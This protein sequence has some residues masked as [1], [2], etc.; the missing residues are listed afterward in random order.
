M[1]R[2]TFDEHADPRLPAAP[3]GRPE[4][5]CAADGCPN[6][7]S[8]HREGWQRFCSAHA[9]AHPKAWPRI[10]QE[11]LDWIEQHRRY[12]EAMAAQRASSPPMPRRAP[13]APQSSS[14]AWRALHGV[15]DAEPDRES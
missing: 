3:V 4:F 6:R 2:T 11:Q 8:V 9:W 7:W 15:D 12:G 14:R 1:S 13:Q 10:T 5:M